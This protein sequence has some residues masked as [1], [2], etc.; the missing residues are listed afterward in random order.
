M[1][2]QQ[3]HYPDLKKEVIL[4]SGNGY[5]NIV[6]KKCF[7]KEEKFSGFIVD[8]TQIRV[9]KS[10]FGFGLILLNLSTN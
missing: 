7:V 10:I 5:R 6:Q 4:L 9:G 3:K 8:E 2:I 1:V